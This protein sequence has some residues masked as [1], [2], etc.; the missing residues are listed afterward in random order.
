M[1]RV[2][3]AAGVILRADG[4]E[5]LLAQ[6]PP[7]KVYAGY[8]EFP[9]GKLEAGESVREALVRE[10]HE[11]LG[12]RVT[13]CSPWLT[14][15]F[16]YP[17]AAVRI[18]FWR[19]TAWE[20]EIGVSAPVEHSDIAWQSCG[21][22]ASVAPVL[23]ANDPILKA[24]SLP[25]RMRITGAEVLGRSVALARVAAALADGERVIQVRDKGL[26]A[27]E[28]RSL[29][30]EVIALARPYGAL[31]LI[32]DDAALAA[33]L[34]AD[35]VHLSASAL[36]ALAERPALPWV[37]ASCHDARELAQATAL[38]LDYALLGAV[39]PTPSHPGAPGM[40]W[41]A[42]A[43]LV[44]GAHLPVFALGGVAS[45]D[46]AQAQALGAHGVACLRG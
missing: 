39:A 23:P 9:G 5:F 3:V 28:R 21:A 25:V 30:A 24:L 33:E 38:G 43:G 36:M 32:N 40:G 7:G 26:P 8:W 14:R 41:P 4:Q 1:A 34:G 22:A 27:D 42:F 16:I 44:E 19:V 46:L 12:M 11:E 13:A 35:G 45:G 2:E 6:R 10:L 37:G 17:H 20:G 15:E 29:A 18:H 31:V